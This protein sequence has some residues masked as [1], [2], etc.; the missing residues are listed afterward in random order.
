MKKAPY[1]LKNL[2]IRKMPGFPTGLESLND[3]A[4]NINIIAG[5]NASGKSSI[6]RVIQQ[7][8]WHD[9]T[10]GLDVAGSV[11]LAEDLW[12]IKIDSEKTI[13]QKNG[14]Q[15]QING[16][17]SV[18]GQHR[19]LLALHKLVEGNES[20]LAKEIARQSIGGF[21]LDAAQNDLGYTSRIQ[22]KGATAFKKFNEAEVNY[23]KVRDE[24]R[25][26]KGEEDSL[27]ELKLK[28]ENAQEAAR[29]N[30][31]YNKVAD[32]LETKSKF[33]QLTDQMNAFPNSMEKLNGNEYQDIQELEGKI[34]KYQSNI[35]KATEEIEK[36]RK[37]LQKLTIPAEGISDKIIT[38]IE[39]RLEQLSEFEHDIREFDK[40][41][42][43]FKSDESEALKT[44]DDSI[45]PEK[46]KGLKIDDVSGLDKMLQDAHQVLG[47]REFLLSEIK[48]LEEEAKRHEQE[49]KS[50]EI[51]IQGIKTLSD[52]L[53]EPTTS[54]GIPIWVVISISL[55]GIVTA[56]TTFFAGW[57]GLLG[58]ILIVILFLYA[59]STKSKGSNSLNVREKD[60][61]NSGLK[62]PSQWN[63]KNVSNQIDELIE[64][65]RNIKDAEKI[66]QRLKSCKDELNNLQKRTDLLDKKRE[67]W[68]N[69]L[70]TA[71]G[72]P[73]ENTKD[74]SSLYWFLIHVKKWQDA[75]IQ[76]ES[77]EA[78]KNELQKQQ[79]NELEKTNALFEKSNFATAQDAIEGK[80]SFKELKD[81]ES[82]RKEQI[83][84]IEQK[85]EQINEQQ[86]LMEKDA[87]KL[88]KTYQLLSIEE[89]DK[90][91]VQ[92]FVKQLDDYKQTSKKHFAAHENVS[93]KE[94]NL[95]DHSLYNLYKEEIK[96]LS[97]D[98]A[99]AKAS[100]SNKIANELENIQ[101]QITVI[102]TQVQEKKK[103]HELED[104][105]T[106]KE[107]ALDSLHQLYESNLSSAAGDIIINQLKKETQNKNRPI[108]FLRANE[109]FNKITHGRYELLLGEEGEPNFKAYD[110]LL[111]LGQNL[112]ELS[113]GTRVQLLLSIRLAYVETVESSIKLPILADELLA[114]S[115]DERAQAI[116][117]ALIEIS[118]EGRQVF[119]FTA[120]AD[121]VSKWMAHLKEQKELDHKI[122]Q[123]DGSSNES[124]DSNDYKTV[125]DNFTLIPTV[126]MPNGKSHKEYGEIISKQPFNALIQNSTELPL[127]YLIE[128][129]D[130][131]Y[132]CLKR[133]I[134]TWGQLE[135]FFRNDGKIQNFDKEIY[136]QLQN[137]IEL[138]K[139]F[140]ELYRKGRSRPIDRSVL[141][142]SG[143]ISEAFIDKVADKL[144]EL[145]S[146][147][148][149]LIQA[150]R[151]GEVS[152]FRKDKTDELEQYLMSES[153]V[154]DLD[155]L[156][157]EDIIINLQ[158]LISSLEI[159]IE[160]ANNF[161]TRIL[162][163]GNVAEQEKP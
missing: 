45:D 2:S 146:E 24:Q 80:A 104:A 46:W 10:K 120:Q 78:Q 72:F 29:L 152:S 108:V 26:L 100:E 5:A 88:S 30:E 121:E 7:L 40:N 8:V 128:D 44:F 83:R 138:L 145:N 101:K 114:N 125:L 28:K 31:F 99:Q 148:K 36:S 9:K 92:A 33:T 87:E 90:E 81:Q 141:E 158:A 22:S 154:D 96:D 91:S 35:K 111:R 157:S 63:T 25:K 124:F 59:H 95:Q 49:T 66:S 135:S 14:I 150:L 37:E 159:K 123:L 118:K 20:D 103:G 136:N 160:D 107:N 65:L 50:S 137:R 110:T 156:E 133:R 106:R 21:D 69:K 15:D 64:N 126:P 52:W 77:L 27:T 93:E 153:Y 84:F 13:V 79:E 117:E 155:V 115:D 132:D 11:M 71:P 131:L 39:E 105:L 130:L 16:L 129:V 12:E 149:R 34:E 161:I 102:E 98:Q 6:A 60:F 70:Q 86:T 42:A 82:T 94:R 38:E 4:N 122:F 89:N 57:P 32:Y 143:A 23:K 48:S 74:F 68:V 134:K 55:L 109:I 3:L 139:R 151:D 19:Y 17:P 147:P 73:K 97:I 58:L 53:K 54:S 75:H 85:S 144:Y 18:E 47:E 112:S 56:I 62:V 142:S 127:W 43:G 113:T 119:Y 51:F 61:I 76:R 140:Q 1:I 116:I 67:E 162:S 41:I 163:S